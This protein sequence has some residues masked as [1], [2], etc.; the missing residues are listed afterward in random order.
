MD[1]EPILQMERGFLTERMTDEEV[2]SFN[3]AIECYLNDDPLYSDCIIAE[4][5][6][7][8]LWKHVW[9]YRD[10][11]YDYYFGEGAS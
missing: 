9:H 7:K 2:S 6:G 5:I 8:A 4:E 3:D 11:L 1:N 10:T